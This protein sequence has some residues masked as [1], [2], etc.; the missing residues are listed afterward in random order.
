MSV[1]VSVSVSVPDVVNDKNYPYDK[2]TALAMK[3]AVLYEC[4]NFITKALKRKA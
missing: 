3:M 4:M 2:T 1:C